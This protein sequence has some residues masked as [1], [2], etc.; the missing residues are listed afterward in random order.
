M[1]VRNYIFVFIA[2]LFFSN[3]KKEI[4]SPHLL[5][6]NQLDLKPSSANSNILYTI[7]TETGTL[8]DIFRDPKSNF[9]HINTA[10]LGHSVQTH[11]GTHNSSFTIKNTAGTTYRFT[12]PE[13]VQRHAV[14]KKPIKT[15]ITGTISVLQDDIVLFEEGKNNTASGAIYTIKSTSGTS[16]NIYRAY[17]IK[18]RYDQLTRRYK[19]TLLRSIVALNTK[20]E[21]GTGDTPADFLIK[22]TDGEFRFNSNDIANSY[23]GNNTLQKSLDG[24]IVSISLHGVYLYNTVQPIREIKRESPIE[25]PPTCDE[26]LQEKLVYDINTEAYASNPVGS[27]TFSIKKEAID[28]KIVLYQQHAYGPGSSAVDYEIITPEGTFTFNEAHFSLAK[29]EKKATNLTGWVTIKRNG[30]ILF[31]EK[32]TILEEIPPL[33]TADFSSPECPTDSYHSESHTN[34]KRRGIGSYFYPAAAPSGPPLVL[35]VKFTGGCLLGFRHLIANTIQTWTQYAHVTFKFLDEAST[36]DAEIRIR[37][38]DS[39][40]NI[41]AYSAIGTQ[42]LTIPAYKHTMSLPV[43]HYLSA[44]AG[45]IP[46]KVVT[47]TILHEFGHALGLTHEHQRGDVPFEWNKP[48]IYSVYETVGLTKDQIDRNLFEVF[49]GD[50]S[51]QYDPN[52]IMNYAFSPKFFMDCVTRITLTYDLSSG[53]IDFIGKMY[54]KPTQ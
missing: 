46:M 12:L 10:T 3:C 39:S 32:K 35:R 7:H 4:L 2:L 45:K 5:S 38:G 26:N 21:I 43:S 48:F 53:D 15:A 29:D 49:D 23:Q 25:N 1:F 40:D 31:D 19:K 24:N 11:I 13:L 28:G 6:K 22:T 52:S 14:N 54:P 20:A 44:L 17:K 50:K 47:R 36:E 16:V 30:V 51:A 41:G 37:V 8:I 27:G 18:W 9:L 42:A 34:R 33:C